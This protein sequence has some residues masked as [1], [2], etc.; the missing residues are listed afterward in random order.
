L[1]T[2]P[3][4]GTLRELA[5][6]LVAVTCAAGAALASVV[7]GKAAIEAKDYGRAFGL[8]RPEAERGDVEAQFYVGYMLA[9]GLGVAKDERAAVEWYRKAAEQGDALAQNNLGV[10]Y[11]HGLGVAKDE[12][13]AVEWYRKA[14][15]QG[16]A[17]AQNNLGAMYEHGR[18]VLQDFSEAAR[19][20]EKAAV[21]GNAYGQRNLARLL[22]DGM[23]VKVDVVRAHAWFNLASAAEEPHPNAAG[24]RDELAR[25]MTP[26]QIAEA[27]R[28]ARAWQPGLRVGEQPRKG[29]T[30]KAA[31]PPSP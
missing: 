7:E 14:A 22:R 23:G 4:F 9:N 30:A 27:Q 26:A 11:E 18:G 16:H 6:C 5:I 8:F 3:M 29:G 19:L 17:F 10:M 21:N 24:E 20:Y 31:G 15:A 25:R 1:E 28:L 2:I 13:A 12:R